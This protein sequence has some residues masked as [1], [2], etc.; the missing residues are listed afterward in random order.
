MTYLGHQPAWVIAC[1]DMVDVRSNVFKADNEKLRL[2]FEVAQLQHQVDAR[3]DRASGVD[4]CLLLGT[5]FEV[6]LS[7]TFG[8][9]RHAKKA[10]NLL[11]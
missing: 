2:G 6:D 5:Q 7:F 8:K 3:R 10:V 9:V 1:Q 11:G 4:C